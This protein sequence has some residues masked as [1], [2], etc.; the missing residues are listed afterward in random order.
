MKRKLKTTVCH[1]AQ[2]LAEIMGLDRCH[3]IEWE[4]RS[5]VTDKIIESFQKSGQ[6]ITSIAKKAQ[7]SRA[8]IT[9]IL[10]SNS[11]GISLDVLFKVLSA[12]G[13]KIQISYKKAA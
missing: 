5:S 11:Y 2:E 6:T 12:V 8:R 9:K 1:N 7:T 13:Q 4:L 10:K 3:A